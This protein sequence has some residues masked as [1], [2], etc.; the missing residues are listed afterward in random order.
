M[1]FCFLEVGIWGLGFNKGSR[2]WPKMAV[3]VN[4]LNKCRDREKGNQLKI[5]TWRNVT[6]SVLGDVVWVLWS[7]HCQTRLLAI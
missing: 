2:V 3:A 7:I 1:H 5:F 6:I 4:V